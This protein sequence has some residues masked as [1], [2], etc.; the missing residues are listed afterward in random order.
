MKESRKRRITFDI[1]PSIS[2]PQKFEWILS[3]LI[4]ELRWSCTKESKNTRYRAIAGHLS[5]I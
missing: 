2:L 4:G 5:R 3:G 1:D